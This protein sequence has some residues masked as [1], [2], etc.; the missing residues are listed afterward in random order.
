MA[1]QE[2]EVAETKKAI[3]ELRARVEK[4]TSLLDTGKGEVE[5]FTKTNPLVALGA[6]FL[7]GMAMGAIV[8]AVVAS[9]K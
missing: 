5:E 4:L 6:A 1:T 8:V 3:D 2:T 9:R 7:T